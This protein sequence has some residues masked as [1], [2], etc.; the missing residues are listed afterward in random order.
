VA[1]ALKTT[2]EDRDS[3]SGQGHSGNEHC[4][5]HSPATGWQTVGTPED[6][7]NVERLSRGGT[8]PLPYELRSAIEPSSLWVTCSVCRRR[9][10]VRPTATFGL[11]VIC[12]R[13]R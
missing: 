4:W 9:A 12:A 11:G 8:G 6:A 1:G 13:Q 3:G 5:P 10:S 7:G 2:C